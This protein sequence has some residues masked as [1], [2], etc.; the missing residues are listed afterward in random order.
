[1]VV[2]A[3]DY[4]ADARRFAF[5]PRCRGIGARNRET[6]TP[7]ERRGN[8]FS[9]ASAKRPF[10]ARTDS[11]EQPTCTATP[12]RPSSRAARRDSSSS[13]SGNRRRGGQP[14]SGQRHARLPTA[15]IK[16]PSSAEIS[17]WVPPPVSSVTHWPSTER[18]D[19][20]TPATPATRAHIG[21]SIASRSTL[22]CAP[23][24]TRLRSGQAVGRCASRPPTPRMVQ[25]T[26]LVGPS[27]D[28]AE[29]A[30]HDALQRGCLARPNS[31]VRRRDPRGLTEHVI[32]REARDESCSRS[33]SEMLE[34]ST[35]G[36]AD[37]S[38]RQRVHESRRRRAG[39]RR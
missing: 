28:A 39:A 25:G 15:S 27:A 37:A 30:A 8:H 4:V 33:T 18:H 36:S 12:P 19:R 31:R 14:H 11:G 2:G 24:Q 38:T 3:A 35:K 34:A 26:D 21:I 7:S 9:C 22:A 23:S 20:I 16:Q 32:A 6:P 10:A 1:M 5:R 13:S 29:S 17:S